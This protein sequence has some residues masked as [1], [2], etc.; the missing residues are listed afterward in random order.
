VIA[1][2]CEAGVAFK[3]MAGLYHPVRHFDET[4]QTQMHGFL[5]V[6]G[7]SVLVYGLQ[8]NEATIETILAEEQI[9]AFSFDVTGFGWENKRVSLN[10]YRES[11]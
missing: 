5:K 1:R 8:L 4:V 6:F 2:R 3:A 9:D 11:T 10:E 7:T